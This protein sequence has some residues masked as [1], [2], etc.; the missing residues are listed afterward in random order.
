MERVKTHYQCL[1][2]FISYQVSMHYFLHIV[3]SCEIGRNLPGLAYLWGI[4][5]LS[6]IWYQKRMSIDLWHSALILLHSIVPLGY[7][8]ASTMIHYLTQSLIKLDLGR[9]RSGYAASTE[10]AVFSFANLHSK[11]V[12]ETT[13]RRFAFGTGGKKYPSYLLKMV[14]ILFRVS[15]NESSSLNYKWL[16]PME[17]AIFED[18]ICKTSFSVAQRTEFLWGA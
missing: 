13:R 10:T 15:A 16:P 9:Q 12:S 7:R 3:L 6:N 17:S 2:I 8:A 5:P 11:Y 4:T 18:P 1:S 14:A